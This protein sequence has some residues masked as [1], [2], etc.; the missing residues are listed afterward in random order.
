MTAT[1]KARAMVLLG[2]MFSL[3][4]TVGALAIVLLNRRPE[5]RRRESS[6]C[7]VRS[8]RVCYWAEMLELTSTQQDTMLKF[9]RHSE[10]ATD[11]IHATIRPVMDS[12]YQTI[13]P[14]VDSQRLILREQIRTVLTPAQR[15]KYDSTTRSFDE[16]RRQGRDRD[17]KGG[18]LRGRP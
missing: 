13:R 8:G 5:E 7:T 14:R 15:T 11:S 9:Y 12:I 3:G 4:L 10:A 1:S 16:E 6:T 18:Q 2:A 17:A